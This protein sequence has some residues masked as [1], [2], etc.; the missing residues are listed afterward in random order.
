MEISLPIFYCVVIPNLSKSS[1]AFAGQ[2]WHEIHQR[3]VLRLPIR[4]YR[5]R[6]SSPWFS[7]CPSLDFL[8]VLHL[9]FYLSSTWFS[10]SFLLDAHTCNLL[11]FSY[12]VLG[13]LLFA[14]GIS[15][16]SLA[17]VFSLSWHQ[18]KDTTC[19]S[20]VQYPQEGSCTVGILP[21]C[22]AHYHSVLCVNLF[23][24]LLPLRAP[25]TPWSL[26]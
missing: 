20:D 8:L 22:N 17:P 3:I 14:V 23:F 25:A 1:C 9:I 2:Q 26:P 5:I 4:V 13:C 16:P 11:C 12:L 7:T 6:L 19:Q 18:Y 10:D 21:S 15:L 24:Q